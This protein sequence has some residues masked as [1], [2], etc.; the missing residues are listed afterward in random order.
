VLLFDK[1]KELKI[2]NNKYQMPFL[3]NTQKAIT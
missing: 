1:G 3:D 2:Y